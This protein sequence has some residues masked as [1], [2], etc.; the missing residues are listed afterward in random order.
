[1]KGKKLPKLLEQMTDREVSAYLGIPYRK[2]NPKIDAVKLIHEFRKEAE[3]RGAQMAMR[4]RAPPA[5]S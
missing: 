3:A 1:M 4:H 2:A 5:D